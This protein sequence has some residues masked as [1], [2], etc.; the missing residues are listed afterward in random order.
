MK[1]VFFLAGDYWHPAPMVRPVADALFD[2]AQWRVILTERPEDFLA[3]DE[4]PDLIVTFKE[5]VENN[6]IPTPNWLDDAWA[7][8]L[9]AFVREGTGLMVMHAALCDMDGGHPVGRELTQSV[10]RWHPAQCPLTFVPDAEHPLLEGV[11][12][13]TFPEPDEHYV[14]EMLPGFDVTV[15]AHTESVNGSQPAMWCKEYGK[16][17]VCCA[18]PGHVTPNLVCE[19]Y[20]KVMRNAVKWCAG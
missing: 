2:P 11:E 1:T 16:G 15:I 10:F 6:T 4:A 7:R 5:P 19:P 12:A 9:L 18:A 17:R 14:M 3:L 20:L 13:F 8:K